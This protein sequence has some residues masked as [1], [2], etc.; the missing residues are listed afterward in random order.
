M[1][2]HH[3]LLVQRSVAR[4]QMITDAAAALFYA[5]LFALDPSLRPLFHGDLREQGRTLMQ[6]LRLT[7]AGL[8]HVDV[9]IPAVQ[10]LGRRHA[11]NGVT[12]NHYATVGEALLWTLEKGLG[13]EFT[14]ETRA[15]WVEVYEL[16]TH[17][18]QAAV[19]SDHQFVY[20]A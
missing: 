3:K 20:P 6:M 1:H 18:M 4:V 14:A 12:P 19:E 17:T 9:L 8:D 11:C 13:P 10:A 2:V 15:A 7:V 5:R 16:L